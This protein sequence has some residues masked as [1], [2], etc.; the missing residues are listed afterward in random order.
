MA[1]PTAPL[2][3]KF[4]A[5]ID[6]R[7]REYALAEGAARI[8]DNVDVTRD[9][10][11]ICRSGTRNISATAC[12]SLWTHPN[13]RFMLAVVG[14]ALVRIN[15]DETLTSLVA[16][17]GEVHYA[18]LNDAVYWTDGSSVGQVT[19]QG[20]VGLWGMANPPCPQV[21]AASTG[22][23]DTTTTYTVAIT[24]RHSSGVESGASEP[25]SITT[26]KNVQVTLPSAVGVTFVVYATPANSSQETL[27]EVAVVSP[28][29]TVIFGPTQPLKKKLESLWAERPLPGQ[30]L[31]AHKGRLWVAS[32]SVVWFT[33]VQSP[34]WLFPTT[35]YYQFESDV[36]MLGAT[37]DGLYVG[38]YDRVYYLQGND[39]LDM[40][41]RL[42]AGVG[43]V[44]GTGMELPYDLF[45]GEGAFPTRQCAWWDQD[46]F[47]CVG[48]PGGIIVRPFQS[49]FSA[50]ASTSGVSGYWQHQGLRQVVSALSVDPAVSVERA[51]QAV[52]TAVASV[53]QNGVVLNPF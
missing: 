1:E 52:D 13:Q 24:A 41:Q 2:V 15:P 49:R 44:S 36:T 11:V 42:V 8:L 34:H 16:G 25:V 48:K 23:Y 14:G 28:G 39:P 43:A 45:L 50:G 5:G 18:L 12:H 40:K 33:S 32:G 20:E 47:W 17:V 29:G 7:S 51:T 37:E 22:Q 3:L 31:V 21:V 38:L 35:G 30:C 46:G 9:G 53:F 6:N 10:G 4:P 26:D 27:R 19:E